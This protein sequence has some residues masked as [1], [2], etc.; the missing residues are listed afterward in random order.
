MSTLSFQ[1]R[2]EIL[3]DSVKYDASCSCSGTSR[4]SF[5]GATSGWDWK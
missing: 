2:L 3:A 4:R 5:C 1:Q